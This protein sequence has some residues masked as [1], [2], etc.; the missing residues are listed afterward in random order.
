MTVNEML[1]KLKQD[2]WYIIGQ[3][4]SHM[5]L[6][7]DLKKGKV[8][9]PNHKGDIPIFVLNSILKQAKLK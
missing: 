5:Q 7:H 6:K 3:K 2:G 9:V 1:R 4:G 8:T